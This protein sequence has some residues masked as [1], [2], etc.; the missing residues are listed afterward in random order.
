MFWSVFLLAIPYGVSIIEV[1][2]GVQ[3]FPS[4][5]WL[6]LPLLV[7][8]TLLVVWA[9]MTFAVRGGGTPMP[10]DPPREFVTTGPYAYVRHPFVAGVS[11][12][13]VA[14]GIILGSGPVISY[15]AVVLALWY[16]GVRPREERVLDQRFG[17]RVKE[18]R[19]RVRG[20]R[21]F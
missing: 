16:Y 8:S 1:E 7:L 17:A 18:Y 15:A 11:G 9:A 21:P 3:R 2:L 19:R 12:Q 10:L 6:A 20:F 5:L 4:Q 14:M 13:I